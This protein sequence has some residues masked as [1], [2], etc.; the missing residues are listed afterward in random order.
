[1][2]S[3]RCLSVVVMS[4]RRL[5]ARRR[6]ELGAYAHKSVSQCGMPVT[7]TLSD[8]TA[9]HVQPIVV[10]LCDDGSCASH[11]EE[12]LRINVRATSMVN[13][14]NYGAGVITGLVSLSQGTCYWPSCEEPIVRFVD[15]RPVN[16]F[17]TAHIRAANKGGRRYVEDMDDKERTASAT[18]SCC[19]LS[20]T[21]SSTS[22]D[23]TTSQSR[24]CRIGNR[25]GKHPGRQHCEGC[26]TSPKS[27]YRN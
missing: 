11:P 20:I 12:P 1:M 10:V 16:N 26:A 2:S 23:Q 24:P 5:Q 13:I 14:R 21:R 3:L 22:C 6:H 18:L 17:E 19:V 7:L 9:A 15:G 25:P 8:H 4:R 27:G